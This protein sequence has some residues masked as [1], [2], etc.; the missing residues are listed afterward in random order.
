VFTVVG[1][2]ALTVVYT[3]IGM[4][5][6]AGVATVVLGVVLTMVVI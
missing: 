2:I 6:L 5:P 1:M 3:A 4:I